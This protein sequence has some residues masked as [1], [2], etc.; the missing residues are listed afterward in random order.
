MGCL[1]RRA[2]DAGGYVLR[3]GSCCQPLLH[4]GNA[5]G[6]VFEA[7]H[8][9]GN[10]FSTR[11]SPYYDFG[12][13]SGR[14]LEPERPIEPFTADRRSLSLGTVIRSP[15]LQ[16]IRNKIINS[17]YGRRD[18]VIVQGE[19]AKHLTVGMPSV[20]CARCAGSSVA[21]RLRTSGR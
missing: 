1:S 11:A 15:R 10:G 17:S 4:R 21:P 3:Q 20:G 5:S 8:L 6:V 2:F 7:L 19:V 9:Q 13:A 18:C 12:I 14:A 16:D